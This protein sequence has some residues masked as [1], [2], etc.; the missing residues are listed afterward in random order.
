[1]WIWILRSSFGL[2]SAGCRYKYRFCSVGNVDR[3]IAAF[4]HED[5]LPSTIFLSECYNLLCQHKISCA[6]QAKHRDGIVPMGIETDRDKDHLRL[7]S[8]YKRGED[9]LCDLFV[10]LIPCPRRQRDIDDPF[11]CVRC[12]FDPACAGIKPGLILMRG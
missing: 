9:P 12:I 5:D 7:E 3:I 10:N 8:L 11:L 6:R 1:M 4:E 2:A